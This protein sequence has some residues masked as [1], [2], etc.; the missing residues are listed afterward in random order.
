VTAYIRSGKAPKGSDRTVEGTFSEFEKIA[1]L[2]EEHDIVV[3]A[4]NSFTNE[5]V[6]AIVAGL[7]KRQSSAKGRLIHISGIEIEVREYWQLLIDSRCWQ[8]HRF[9]NYGRIQ[10]EQ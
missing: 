6:S 4:G 5:P 3:N 8:L 7:R 10:P 9:W 2:S 1:G